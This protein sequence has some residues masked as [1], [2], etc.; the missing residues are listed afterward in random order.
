MA[1]KVTNQLVLL[2]NEI[3]IDKVVSHAHSFELFLI[4]PKPAKKLYLYYSS[5]DCIIKDRLH[6]KGKCLLQPQPL[7][8]LLR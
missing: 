4:I 5:T 3:R 8:I 6:L 7:L 1:L 2:P